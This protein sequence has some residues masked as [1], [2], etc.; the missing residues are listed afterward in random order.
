MVAPLDALDEPV[1]VALDHH[2]YVE[3]DWF[4][5]DGAL[6]ALLED[7]VIGQHVKLE[8]EG[9]VAVDLADLTDVI[10][11][12]VLLVDLEDL[13]PGHHA[14]SLRP[15][16]VIVEVFVVPVFL[17]AMGHQV[18]SREEVEHAGV[19]APPWIKFFL[20]SLRP[21]LVPTKGD[22]LTLGIKFHH[23]LVLSPFEGHVF[24]NECV[25]LAL[26]MLHKL[27]VVLIREF[28]RHATVLLLRFTVCLDDVSAFFLRLFR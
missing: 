4:H 28:A 14:Q 23:L 1:V 27:L 24:E 25:E 6:G 13:P 5:H 3:E 7:A 21:E 2:V 26:L 19:A 11:G 15:S 9:A 20:L 8:V 16:V 18:L 22:T 10:R 12:R 17:L